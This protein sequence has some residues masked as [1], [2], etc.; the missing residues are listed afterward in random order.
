MTE[1]VVYMVRR[2]NTF[3]FPWEPILDCAKIE[4]CESLSLDYIYKEPLHYVKNYYTFK[5]FF[6]LTS[7]LKEEIFLWLWTYISECT[8]VQV[9]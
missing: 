1:R 3:W 6:T 7:F 2:N 9:S 4:F 5:R 8:A